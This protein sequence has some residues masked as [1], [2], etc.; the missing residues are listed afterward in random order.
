LSDNEK[1]VRITGV[2]QL[3]TRLGV[4]LVVEG[5]RIFIPA[6]CTSNPSEILEVGKPTT[7]F[8]VRNYAEQ[9]GLLK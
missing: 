5:R 6:N 2:V 4:F 3:N 1:F 7:V 9:Q 8:V